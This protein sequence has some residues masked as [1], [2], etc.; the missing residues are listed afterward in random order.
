MHKILQLCHG[1]IIPEYSSAYAKRCNSLFNNSR[2]MS[3]GGLVYRDKSYNRV[4]QYHSYLLMISSYLNGNR[5]FEIFL[6]QNRHVR[7]RYFNDV[8]NEIKKSDVIVFEGPWQ[9]SIFK[10]YIDDKFIVYDAHNVEYLLRK[11]NIYQS[12][13]ME[14]EAN[15]LKNAD[16]IISLSKKDIENFVNIYNIKRDKIY[17]VPLTVLKKFDY[18]GINSNYIVFIGSMYEPNIKA[19][20]FINDIAGNIDIDFYI[21]GSVSSHKLRNKK[22]NVKLLGLVPEDEKNKILSNALFAINPVPTGS[23]R[24][25]KMLDYISHGL[26]VITTEPGLNGYEQYNIGKTVIV[27]GI[28][29]FKNNIIKLLNNKELIKSMSNASFDLFSMIINEEN[30]YSADDIIENLMKRA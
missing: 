5:S 3:I 30:S 22:K 21:I 14:I 18:N 17:Y 9:Y 1:R 13:V 12:Y 29:D 23:G 4:T 11:N 7:K 28:N 26:P 15:L 25:L 24:N 8:L 10:D 20:D 6:S 16:V 27:S 2:I 19:L